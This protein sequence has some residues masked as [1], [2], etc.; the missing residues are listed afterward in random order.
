MALGLIGRKIG[1]TR[2]FAKDGTAIPVTVIEFP[3]NYVVQI[4]TVETD[5]YNAIQ[6]G[7][8]PAKEKHL[9]KPLIYH[10][11]KHNAPLLRKLKE[12][13]VD[14]PQ[15]FKEGQE[16]KVEDVFKPGDVV[17][18]VGTSKG[19]GFAGVMKRWDF[20]GFP[21]SHGHRYHRAVGAIGQRTDPGRVWKG[22]KMP[23]H[24]GAETVRVQGLIVV[25]VVPEKNVIL[26]KGSV[27]GHTKGIVIVEHSKLAKRKKKQLQLKRI[28]PLIESIIKEGEES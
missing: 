14:N 5:G 6:V 9:T 1:M 13:R 25:D 15:D 3:V 27:P 10:F 18:V 19:R 17:D 4:K 8:F 16:L 21:K 26:V 11:K 20:A 23:G 28:M 2:V 24:Y 7:A 22:K 12:F